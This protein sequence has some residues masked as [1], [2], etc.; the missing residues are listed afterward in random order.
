[1]CGI[2]AVLRRPGRERDN[3][4]V[5]V[6]ATA[7]QAAITE[8]A[9][10]F[11]PACTATR[12]EGGEASAIT[13]ELQA[14]AAALERAGE[15][16]RTSAGARALVTDPILCTRLREAMAEIERGT[17]AHEQAFDRRAREL[18]AAALEVVAR[19][20][21][22]VRDAAWAIARDALG[23]AEAVADLAGGSTGG[24]LVDGLHAVQ[25][26]L[27]A[28]D[29]LEV[30]G[31]DSLGVVVVVK[32]HGLALDHPEIR[33]LLRGRVD[34]PL[35]THRA[36]RVAS[37]ALV[38][39]YKTAQEIGELGDNVRCIRAAVREDALL[40][41]ALLADTAEVVVLGHTRWASVGIISEPNAHPLT[42]E[43]V[44]AVPDE[45]AA[46]LLAV[47]N[48]DVDNHADLRAAAGLALAP[49]IT[50]DA[51]VIPAL[52]ARQTNA[53]ASTEEAFR[54]TVRSFVGSVAIAMLDAA[55]P[56][57]LYLAL[58]GSGQALYVGLA[59]DA[60]LV[61]SEPYGLVEWTNRY[62]RLDG[63]TPGNPANPAASRGQVLVLEA[64]AAGILDGLRRLAY[65]GTVLPLAA[66]ELQRTEITTRDIDRGEFPHFLLKEISE[67]PQSFRKTLRGKIRL[68]DQ[69]GQHDG[70]RRAELPP[71][72]LPEPLAA[73]LRGGAIRRVLVIGQGTAAVAGRGV[74]RALEAL[75]PDGVATV[76][77]PATE[78]SGFALRADMTDTLVIAISQSGTTTDTNRTVDLVRARGAAVVA[79]VNRRHSDLTDKADGVLYTSDGRDVEMSVASTKAFYSQIAAGFLLAAALGELMPAAAAERERRSR[80]ADQLLA[81]LEEMP[82]AL[83]RCLLASPRIAEIAARRAPSRRYWAVVGNGANL[84][85]AEEIRIKLSE[86]C[87]KSIACDATEDKKHIDLSSEPLIVVCAAGLVGGNA[88]DVAKEVAIYR[89]HKATPIV[90]A[91]EGE[92]RFSAAVEL[93][94]VPRVHP[95]LDFVLSV[96]AGHLFGYHAALAID[97]LARPLREA[98]SAIEE[99]AVAGEPAGALLEA[100]RPRLASPGARF[101]RGLGEGVYDGHLEASTA[102]RLAALLRLVDGSV[103]LEAFA[104]E[105]GRQGTPAIVAEELVLALSRAIDQLTRPIDAIKH[106]AKTVTVG[107]SRSDEALLLVPLVRAVL[108]AGAE[109]GNVSYHDLQ[110][111]AALDPLVERVS[112]ST[113]YRIAGDPEDDNCGISVVSVTGI[114][115]GL[116]SRTTRTPVLRGTKRTV[117]IERRLLAARGRSDGRTVL[118]VPE[119]DRG[120][121]RGMLLL[122]VQYHTRALANVLRGA[123]G[124]YRNRYAALRDA[125][126]ETEPAFRAELLESIDVARLLV[127]PIHVLAEEWRVPGAAERTP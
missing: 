110:T 28:L 61:A 34:D 127:E 80:A 31:R 72:V 77:L 10:I 11:R 45:R 114:S 51:K 91:T 112:G 117:A 12:W 73:R 111:L 13:G 54:E 22:R 94:P 67:S 2:V 109:R 53:G 49:E 90:I 97:R 92:Q 66:S 37:G 33:E 89:A 50:T 81:A 62:L 30:R 70:R 29:R 126:T 23:T 47:L 105:F 17:T 124:G 60:F 86:L 69:P 5:R 52:V 32:G 46:G 25:L 48:G 74:A 18:D 9:G 19:E 87:Y 39:V 84:V 120:V 93:I 85:A 6:V 107:I 100:L 123:L 113:R 118:L 102:V 16:L 40:R 78:L 26:V 104:I 58:R 59:E 27:A 55:H 125:V 44:V 106:Q 7:A 79:I 63:E 64:G 24:A 14:A 65:D 82:A 68:H 1:M 108:E 3:D 83:E 41:R 15:L 8:A 96:M 38:L 75:L 56:E 20:L 98:R 71:Q 115:T 121:V 21:R 35:V 57:R 122:H 95:E 116:P 36:V 4:R 43:E 99:L 103:P 119:V 88:D 76:A 42:G 101:F